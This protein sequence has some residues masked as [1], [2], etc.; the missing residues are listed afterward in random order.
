MRDVFRYSA[1]RSKVAENL[2]MFS[3]NWP[4]RNTK[5]NCMNRENKAIPQP[6]C[7]TKDVLTPHLRS[8]T[9]MHVFDFL[10]NEAAELEEILFAFG[11]GF[12]L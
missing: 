8:K 5:E 11:F 3:S 2:V 7:S 4:R 1:S 12:V 6:T 10:L 9:R